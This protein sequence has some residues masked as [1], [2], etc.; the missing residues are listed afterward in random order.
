MTIKLKPVDLTVFVSMIDSLNTKFNDFSKACKPK[1][2]SLEKD[3]KTKAF[4]RLNYIANLVDMLSY[5]EANFYFSPK[6]KESI[7]NTVKKEIEELSKISGAEDKDNFM[8]IIAGNIM[9]G[10]ND[11]SKNKTIEKSVLEKFHNFT[12]LTYKEYV[13]KSQQNAFKDYFVS[14]SPKRIKHKIWKKGESKPDLLNEDNTE[15]STDK[16]IT[17]IYSNG[18][19]YI[20]LEVNDKGLFVLIKNMDDKS[21][22]LKKLISVAELKEFINLT[23]VEEPTPVV[24]KEAPKQAVAKPSATLP[25]ATAS[26]SHPTPP[27]K[28]EAP[29]KAPEPVV[30]DEEEVVDEQYEVIDDDEQDM[31]DGFIENEENNKE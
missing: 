2:I 16:F 8:S 6:I 19:D 1:F 30:E 14:F 29:A 5:K 26:V 20:S 25:V 4:N 21:K 12:V 15:I 27:P 24:V 28:A 23:T 18:R 22:D 10:H 17:E 11:S 3:D 31:L 13:L 9:N 7:L